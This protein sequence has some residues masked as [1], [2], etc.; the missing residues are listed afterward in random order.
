MSISRENITPMKK[1]TVPGKRLP[2]TAGPAAGKRI[3]RMALAA[4]VIPI[5]VLN[6]RSELRTPRMAGMRRNRRDHA[7]ITPHKMQPMGR[8]TGSMI[9]ISELRIYAAFKK[10]NRAALNLVRWSDG[11]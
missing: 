2:K 9:A 1:P 8:I 5:A 4:V 10:S 3:E 6:G 7:A 11:V